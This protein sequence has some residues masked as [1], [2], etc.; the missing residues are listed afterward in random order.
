MSEFNNRI[1][2]QRNILLK[3]NGVKWA[4]ELFGLS[5]GAII[6]WARINNLGEKSE[7][8]I[9][10]DEAAE[11]LFF[12]SNKSQEQITEEYKHLSIEV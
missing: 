8:V 11:K 1:A 6:R 4:E 2:T 5:S 3:V 12:L 10:I 9:L 7:L